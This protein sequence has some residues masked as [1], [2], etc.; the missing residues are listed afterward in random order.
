M[1]AIG[2]IGDKRGLPT[3]VT[4]QRAG[5]RELQ[6]TI[7]AA[8][9][10]LGNNCDG[11][12]RFVRESLD[13]AARN[14]GLP[15][16]GAVGSDSPRRSLRDWPRRGAAGPVRAGH[17][18]QRPGARPD[19][20]G[21]GTGRDAQSRPTA[22]P[23]AGPATPGRDPPAAR[24]L[25]HARRGLR[26]GTFLRHGASA[27]LG[28][29]GRRARDALRPRSSSPHWNSD[30]RRDGGRRARR[31][32]AG[33]TH[34]LQVVWSG[35]RRGARS[36]ATHPRPGTGHLHAR[37]ALRHRCLWRAVPPAGRRRCRPGAG[38]ERRWRRDQ[39]EGRL[40]DEPPH[41]HRR[42]PGQSL[43]QRHPR[44]GRTAAV[45][46]RLPG[47]RPP[48]ARRRRGHRCRPGPRLQGQR[49][50][51]ARRRDRGDARFLRQ[52]RVRPGRF[53]RRPGRT[54]EGADRRSHSRRRR[55]D[56]PALVGPAHQRV[57]ARPPHRL[58]HA[59]ARHPRSHPGTRA[60][61]SARRCCGRTA[62][63]S[64][65]CCRWSTTA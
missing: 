40:H 36:G 29:A 25:R 16:T 38:G 54:S 22:R 11:H 46:S 20:P 9:C 32:S 23:R 61:A 50:R 15:G 63:I 62:P 14:P 49:V 28:L 2:Q 33:T 5:E 18:G 59:D 53:H 52:P 47:H 34:G 17:A 3:L 26:G 30:F 35:H 19:C 21:D 39:A 8:I 60:A 56:R 37:R 55:P 24:C 57:L 31:R 44:A 51:A 6:P 43:R 64:T 42:G 27:V 1:R 48:V 41:H 4:V 10:G 58:R 7:A 12:A 65:R 45:L 13:F